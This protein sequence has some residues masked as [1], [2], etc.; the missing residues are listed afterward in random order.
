MTSASWPP[1]AAGAVGVGG[2]SSAGAG[3]RSSAGAGGR[4]SAGAGGRSSVSA[5]ASSV[6]LGPAESVSSVSSTLPSETRSPILTQSCFTTPATGAGTSIS[7]LSDYSVTT[8]SSGAGSS[9][10]E[11]WISITGTSV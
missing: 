11:T 2:R 10:T 1:A 8:G 7:A 3:G 9:P 6:A 4:S 5:G